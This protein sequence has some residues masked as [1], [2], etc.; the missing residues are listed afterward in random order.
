M[1]QLADGT[2]TAT[3]TYAYD[4]FG[5][6]KNID[7]SDTNPFR[8]CGEYYDAE[9]GT[10]YLRA[11]YYEPN[12]G[13][14]LSEDSVTG[15]ANDPLSL[16]LYTYC[17]NDSVNYIDITGHERELSYQFEMNL[18]ALKDSDPQGHMTLAEGALAY[19]DFVFTAITI[20]DG[21]YEVKVL[22][23]GIPIVIKG[24]KAGSMAEA[25]NAA[26]EAIKAELRI[27]ARDTAAT[28]GLSFKTG[29]EGEAY[30]FK[31]FG[32]KPQKYFDTPYGRRFVDVFADGIAHESKVG[33]V[34]L[35]DFV[36]TQIRKD[37]YARDVLGEVDEIVWN[38]FESGVTGKKG[39]SGPLCDYLIENNIKVIVH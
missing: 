9:T 29:K 37:I 36:K 4:A 13:R 18:Q 26:I 21:V 5:N 38:F 39:P 35:T 17:G 16:N 22:V 33:Y 2:G 25:K 12:I 32:G 6:E 30:L 24:V 19:G 11:R 14:F 23:K 10:I 1:V 15:T 31:L 20:L 3:K 34:S 28:S 27:E 7:A 8:Y